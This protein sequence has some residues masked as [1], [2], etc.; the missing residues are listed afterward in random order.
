MSFCSYSR[1]MNALM[2]RPIWEVLAFYWGMNVFRYFAIAGGAWLIFWK[3]LYPRMKPKQLYAS[4]PD[5]RHRKREIFYS[6]LTTVIFLGP[7]ALIVTTRGMGIFKIYPSI[8]DFGWVWYFTSF[9]VLGLWHETYFYWIHRFMH[10]GPIYRHV[11]HVHHLSREPTPFTAFAFHPLEAI[12]ESAAFVL[13]ALVFPLHSSALAIFALFSF[14]MNVYGHLGLE[15]FRHERG[16]WVY[17]NSPRY[18]AWHHRCYRGNYSLYTNFWD[19]WMG[20]AML[21]A[22]LSQKKQPREQAH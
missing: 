1:S 13:L 21:P 15:I 6:I 4:V 18:H 7:V 14:V 20:T 9:I 2:E 8:S 10:W 16:P 12:L 17:V 11:H 19:R 5:R 22:S 3:W